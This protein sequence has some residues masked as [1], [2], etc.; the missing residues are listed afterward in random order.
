M[1]S[2]RFSFEFP[3]SIYRLTLEFEFVVELLLPFE[4]PFEFPFELVFRLLLRFVFRL[5]F[6]LLL[7]FESVFWF[8]FISILEF[9]SELEFILESEFE[10]EFKFEF[11]LPF[12]FT[13]FWFLKSTGEFVLSIE[14]SELPTIKTITNN[15]VL[16][17][18][19][20]NLYIICAPLFFIFNSIS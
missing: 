15:P 12:R 2:P 14:A 6:R 10:F 8:E 11:E 4:L 16:I 17:A 18:A 1:C 3:D 7:R 20:F 9:I 5:L 13:L 19:N